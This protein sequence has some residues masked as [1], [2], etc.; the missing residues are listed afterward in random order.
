MMV[1][2]IKQNQSQAL[3]LHAHTIKNV[4]TPPATRMVNAASSQD[5]G[6][7]EDK[8]ACKMIKLYIII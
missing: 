5:Q 2:Y 8:T 7:N 1:T 3:L 4:A 6:C